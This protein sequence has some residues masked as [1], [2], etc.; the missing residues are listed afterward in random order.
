MTPR[1]KA[2]IRDAQAAGFE[3]QAH[4]SGSVRIFKRKGGRTK[5]TQNLVGVT[6]GLLIYAGGG[7]PPAA[8]DMTVDLKTAKSIT[9]YAKMREVLGLAP[10]T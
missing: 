2:L 4:D 3:T 10:E 6:H 5:D 9:S 1:L 8:F 7:A